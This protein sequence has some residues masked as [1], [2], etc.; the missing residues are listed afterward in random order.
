[1]AT[2]DGKPPAQD[3]FTAA[4]GRWAD[5]LATAAHVWSTSVTAA[6]EAALERVEANLREDLAKKDVPREGAARRGPSQR[7]LLLGRVRAAG[8]GSPG[9]LMINS[10]D[11]TLDE[12]ILLAR[13]APSLTQLQASLIELRWPGGPGVG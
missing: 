4:I 6:V 12:V 10:V 9:A 3:A 8:G 7:D 13:N 11:A 2:S 1:M 5:E